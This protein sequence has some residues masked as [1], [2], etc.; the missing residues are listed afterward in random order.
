MLAR[1]LGE[2]GGSFFSF[3]FLDP[4]SASPTLSLRFFLCVQAGLR[5]GCIA[6]RLPC[7]R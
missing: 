7:S 1:S 6:Q 3:C 2:A 4:S 5:G